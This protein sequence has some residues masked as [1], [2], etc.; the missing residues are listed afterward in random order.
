M[1]T[2]NE[3]IDE[4]SKVEDKKIINDIINIE[5]KKIDEAISN[6]KKSMD[7]IKVKKWTGVLTSAITYAGSI[8]PNGNAALS[9][10][11]I[12]S[13]SYI[14]FCSIAN[15]SNSSIQNNI[16]R[17]PYTYLAEIQTLDNKYWYSR[18][19]YDN[20]FDFIND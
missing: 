4:I 17:N 16:N 10:L 15:L 12:L 6:Y 19:L 8:L 2:L 3:L 20:F 1:D 7:I 18:R 11:G 14:L 5:R 13:A 9:M